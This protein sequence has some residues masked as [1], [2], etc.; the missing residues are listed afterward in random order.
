[1]KFKLKWLNVYE[2]FKVGIIHYFE[3]YL[4]GM[5]LIRHVLI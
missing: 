2:I 4:F 1:M 3:Y 5:Y